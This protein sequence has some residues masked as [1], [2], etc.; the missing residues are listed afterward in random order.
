MSIL[1]ERQRTQSLH[2]SVSCWL[3]DG[4]MTIKTVEPSMLVP[5]LDEIVYRCLASQIERKQS[6]MRADSEPA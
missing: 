5:S 3:C 6:V 4:P 1:A 2:A